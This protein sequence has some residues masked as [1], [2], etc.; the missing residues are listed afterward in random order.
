MGAALLLM[1]LPFAAPCLTSTVIISTFV[2]AVAVLSG[3]PLRALLRTLRSVF[4]LGCFTLFFRLFT[5][6]GQP[7]VA[8]G[9]MA[10]TREGLLA[11]G[12][13]IYR[14]CLLVIVASLLTFTTSPSQLAHGLESLLGPLARVGLPVRELAMVLT[15]ALRFVPVFFEEIEKITRAQRARGADVRTG[16]P[17]QRARGWVSVFV[18]I[19]VKAF[20]RAEE[21]ATAMEARGFRGAQHRTRLIEL[22][23]TRQDL[24]AALF[25]L[26][27]GAAALGADRWI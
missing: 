17:W 12:M 26:A 5:T 10:V 8:W 4:W 27:V 18:P 22:R 11:G 19:F 13:Q 6:P 2:A 3:A 21:L 7:L 14:L 9:A 25:V 16:G 20:R 15:I 1:A 23:L 24:A